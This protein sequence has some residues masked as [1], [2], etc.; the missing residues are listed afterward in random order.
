MPRI[1][2]APVRSAPAAYQDLNRKEQMLGLE[3]TEF[4]W[5]YQPGDFFE[6]PL[7]WH[8]G[9]FDLVIDSGRAVATLNV[10]CDQLPEGFDTPVRNRVAAF[11][12]VR[13][14]LIHRHFEFGSLKVTRLSRRKTKATL[15]AMRIPS[16]TSPGPTDRMGR[17]G[18]SNVVDGHQAERIASE[19]AL[20]VSVAP[21]LAESTT[22]R[23]LLASYAAAVTDPDHEL[24]HLYEVRERLASYYGTEETARTTLRIRTDEWN[25][26][27]RLA[28][29]EP[30]QQGR[31]QGKN[32]AGL[33]AATVEELADARA[34]VCRWIV[35]FAKS[36]RSAP[37][38]A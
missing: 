29:S 4:E 9:S 5:S 25:R 6:E 19:T 15:R 16:D 28:N 32:P 3:R 27:G 37:E 10:A 30:L 22:L 38:P 23:A 8:D 7:E 21:K 20:L 34:I 26:F 33:R 35:E 18:S 31:H 17:D 1:A 2:Q 13:R 36:V 14:L 11:F 24:I 12:V